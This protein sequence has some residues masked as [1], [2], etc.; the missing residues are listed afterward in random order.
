MIVVT[1]C[2]AI[3]TRPD[4]GTVATTKGT[5]KVTN[6]VSSLHMLM[7]LL[8]DAENISLVGYRPMFPKSIVTSAT[9]ANSCKC[10]SSLMSRKR[11]DYELAMR[12][13]GGREK[14]C[15]TKFCALH[16]LLHKRLPKSP[17]IPHF[18]VVPRTVSC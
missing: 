15:C 3:A 18:Y 2:A 14:S 4:S 7:V 5:A 8:F 13:K 16:I 10:A 12:D 1:C 11:Q 9:Q 17:K 6:T